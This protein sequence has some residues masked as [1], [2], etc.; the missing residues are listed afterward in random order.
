[1]LGHFV[2][3][4]SISLALEAHFRDLFGD[5]LSGHDVQFALHLDGKKREQISD[6]IYLIG[7]YDYDL[8]R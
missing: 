3:N 2:A 1:M 8:E 6:C 4:E 7:D 5:V